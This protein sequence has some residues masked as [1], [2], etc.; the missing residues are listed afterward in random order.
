MARAQSAEYRGLRDSCPVASVFTPR[1]DVAQA[2]TVS[3]RPCVEAAEELDASVTLKRLGTDL[4]TSCAPSVATL[5]DVTRRVI[6][7]SVALIVMHGTILWY[8]GT[9]SLMPNSSID[10]ATS[11]VRK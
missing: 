10:A 11:H 2:V 6:Y 1:G 5:M 4:A 3:F 8:P 9:L 7:F